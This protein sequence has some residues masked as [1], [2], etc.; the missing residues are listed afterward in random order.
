MTRPVR[1]AGQHFEDI[2][3][4]QSFDMEPFTPLASE[5][6]DRLA[7]LFLENPL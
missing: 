3:R 1:T 4:H 2:S 7:D 6:T 5:K